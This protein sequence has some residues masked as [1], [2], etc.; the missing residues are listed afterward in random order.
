MKAVVR[1][2]DGCV[3][4]S[5]KVRGDWG[6]GECE[7]CCRIK[8]VRG[9]GTTGRV[10]LSELIPPTFGRKHLESDA[11]RGTR[12]TLIERDHGERATPNPPEG[13]VG[14]ARWTARR[15]S[16][17]GWATTGSACG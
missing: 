2:N 4:A 10:A 11:V 13:Y 15:S 12:Q 3:G 17:L 14:T 16:P 8:R 1:L 9:V 6:V 7:K 5:V